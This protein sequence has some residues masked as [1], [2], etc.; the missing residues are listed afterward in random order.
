MGY[1]SRARAGH[2]NAWHFMQAVYNLKHPER[3][4]LQHLSHIQVCCSFTNNTG[5]KVAPKWHS[6]GFACT[7]YPQLMVLEKTALGC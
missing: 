3:T 2:A 7:L 4:Y 1:A 5:C 6:C